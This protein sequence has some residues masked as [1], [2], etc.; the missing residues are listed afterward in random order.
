MFDGDKLRPSLKFY[1]V[2]LDLALQLA[3]DELISRWR[4]ITDGKEPC[5]D[6][7][8]TISAHR[9]VLRTCLALGW[10]ELQPRLIFYQVKVSFDW[11]CRDKHG[12]S[13]STAMTALIRRYL[14]ELPA[15]PFKEWLRWSVHTWIHGNPQDCERHMDD[16]RD[17]A[18][19][20]LE[21]SDNVIIDLYWGMIWFIFFTKKHS[22][23][24]GGCP[25]IFVI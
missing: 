7:S 19:M 8:W 24:G 22:L 20:K 15:S 4:V 11:I 9:L 21:I 25:L 17:S 5:G 12:S 23:T 16:P 18:T 1:R 13:I 3:F 10:F 14:A 2:T 6:R